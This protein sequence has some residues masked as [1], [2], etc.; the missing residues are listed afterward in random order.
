M[1]SYCPKCKEYIGNSGFTKW[2]VKKKGDLM[3]C[4]KCGTIVYM[5]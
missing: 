3:V 5:V 1:I 2:G 4:E